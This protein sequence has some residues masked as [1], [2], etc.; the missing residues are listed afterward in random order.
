MIE[1]IIFDMDGVIS[2]TQKLHSKV[3]QEI[4]SRFGINISSEEITKRYSG[5]KTSEFFDDLL[6][7][8]SR[9]YNL[10]QLMEE[11]WKRMAELGKES[12]DEIEGA[13]ELVCR[14]YKTGFKMAVASASNQTYVKNVIQ[15]LKLE[16]Y[17]E[18]L[19][20]GD[21]V[22]KGKPDPEIFLL[23]A[24]KLEINPENCLVI[25]DGVSGM[26]AAKMGKMKCIGLVKSK[27]NKYPTKNLILSLKEITPEYL[28]DLI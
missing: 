20:S 26:R 19:V 8:T 28:N 7:N 16:K 10:D 24:S 1:A 12:I 14:L 22:A 2:D 5:V 27:N 3:E 13:I 21:M 4:L 15:S 9:S 17:F 18:F 6:K 23:A 25:E 11:K